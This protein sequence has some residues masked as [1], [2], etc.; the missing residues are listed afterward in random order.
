MV[1]KPSC[2]VTKI[3]FISLEKPTNLLYLT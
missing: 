2:P 3:E 1:T